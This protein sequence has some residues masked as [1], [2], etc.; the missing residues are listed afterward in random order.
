MFLNG[1]KLKI[2]KLDV[3]LMAEVWYCL[4]KTPRT[5]Y[6]TLR[7]EKY[8]NVVWKLPCDKHQEVVNMHIRIG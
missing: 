6:N 2:P 5:P 3:E 7:Y 1:F 4:S 8:D